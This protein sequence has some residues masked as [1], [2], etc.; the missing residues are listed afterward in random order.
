MIAHRIEGI[1][2]K[3]IKVGDNLRE[4]VCS[5]YYGI[6][7]VYTVLF[8]FFTTTRPVRH[9]GRL[10]INQERNIFFGKTALS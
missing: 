4:G 5:G 10:M 9:I 3:K 1:G 7:G 6:H 8:A 2:G